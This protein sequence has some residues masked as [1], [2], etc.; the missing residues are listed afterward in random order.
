MLVL[1]HS[2]DEHPV[3][4]NLAHV[5]SNADIAVSHMS[6]QDLNTMSS[7]TQAETEMSLPSCSVKESTTWA[8]I[9]SDANELNSKDAVEYPTTDRPQQN[10][11]HMRNLSK[12]FKQQKKKFK[13]RRMVLEKT[14]ATHGKSVKKIRK[15]KGMPQMHLLTNRE[16]PM[17]W[18]ITDKMLSAEKER[19]ST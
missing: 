11:H 10:N 1:F 16:N 15:E 12:H 5:D 3:D 6:E 13:K 9:T 2:V 14:K 7:V 18:N 4:E 17:K 8:H 19:C